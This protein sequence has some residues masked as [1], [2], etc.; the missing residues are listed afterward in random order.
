MF[1][2]GYM[3]KDF[4]KKTWF[5]PMPVLIVG[6]YDEKGVPNAM[7]AAWGGVWD[8]NQ[9]YL[10]LSP[11]KTTRNIDMKKAFTVSFADAKHVVEADY[12]GIV[13]G[14]EKPNK[15]DLAG[16]H[17]TKSKYV[18]APIIDEF[19]LTLE[20]KLVSNDDGT[21][22]GEIVNVSADESILDKNGNVDPQKLDTI[23]FDPINNAYIKL[24]EKVGNA[25]KDGLKLKE[26]L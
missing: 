4:G 19:P 18:D 24:G 1:V 2:G 7:N 14:D 6:T 23:S 17:T 8:F 16:L 22:I 20:C 13:S 26:S 11:H 15:L 12:V 5:Y 21:V 9:I 10:S 25:F 3:R